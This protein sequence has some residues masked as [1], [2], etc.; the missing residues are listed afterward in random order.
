MNNRERT[1]FEILVREN[2]SMLTAYLSSLL[3][4][5][6]SMD[7]LFQEVMIVAWRR[8]D[9]C[10]LSK[11]FGLW[12]RGIASR[13]VMAEHR[14]RKLTPSLLSDDV[15]VAISEQFGKI[16]SKASDTWQDRSAVLRECIDALPDDRKKIILQRY[17]EDQS[18]QDV[19]TKNDLT[20]EACKKRLQRARSRLVQCLQTRGLLLGEVLSHE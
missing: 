13:L 1:A 7:D 3:V 20:I 10:D 12:L 6:N 5:K 16:D 4:D 2:A 18:A 11:P 15:R 9:D 19:A 14:R 8:L 17:L